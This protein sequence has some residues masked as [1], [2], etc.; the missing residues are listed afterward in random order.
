MRVLV[1]V[2]AM[3]VWASTAAAALPPPG[4]HPTIVFQQAAPKSALKTCS[5]QARSRKAKTPKRLVPVACEQPP[6]A[7]MTDLGGSFWFLP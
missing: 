5:A 7:N 2:V 6:K 1:I 3:L 4:Y